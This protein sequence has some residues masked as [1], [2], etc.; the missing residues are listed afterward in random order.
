MP[1]APSSKAPEAAS[2][3]EACHIASEQVISAPSEAASPTDQRPRRPSYGRAERR[4]R[5]IAQERA[6]AALPLGP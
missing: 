1:D 3:V 4:R 2:C 6:F 5:R